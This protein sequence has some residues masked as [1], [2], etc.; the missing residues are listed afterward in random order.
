[1]DPN[2]KGQ[3]NPTTNES[4]QVLM[5]NPEMYKNIFCFRFKLVCLIVLNNSFIIAL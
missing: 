2:P 5:Q 1:M 4:G 3:N